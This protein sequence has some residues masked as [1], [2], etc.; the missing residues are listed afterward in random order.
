M[1]RQ[2]DLNFSPGPEYLYG[3]AAYIRAAVIVERAGGQSFGAFS[4]EPI[5]QP[6]GMAHRRWRDDF[7]T[8]IPG[9]ATGYSPRACGGY[10]IH[11]PYSN[12]AGNGGLLTTAGDLLRGNASLD[13]TTGGVGQRGRRPCSHRRNSGTA[14][15]R[16]R[17][18][19]HD[20]R[21]RRRADNFPRLVH[22]GLQNVPGPFPRAPVVL[23][24]ARQRGRFLPGAGGARVAE[25]VAQ[26][27]A[28]VC[29][30]AH[31]RGRGR[32]GRVGGPILRR[33][34]RRSDPAHGAR[35]KAPRR[36]PRERV[37]IGPGL[38]SKPGGGTK[39]LFSTATPRRLRITTRNAAVDYR[40]AATVTPT[41]AHLAFS[42]G[43]YRSAELAVAHR[44]SVEAGR[45]SVGHWPG[46][47]LAAKPAFADG[48]RVG[49][50]WHAPF[51]RDAAGAVTGDELTNGRCRH[52]R[53]SRQ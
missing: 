5:F 18:G 20:H 21:G 11:T 38:F 26:A 1:S 52:V 24:A 23:R 46:L 44:V 35:R 25:G 45:L 7:A 14:A 53:F 41:G 31:H 16:F 43:T 13:G 3:N 17:A 9:R 36:R 37:P 4:R 32:T 42:A 40:A 10:A 30:T 8:V 29:A 50:G 33:A 47:P 28:T 39:F 34:N 2:R 48:F 12:L 19:P 49:R 27:A 22:V 51:T 6:R 15:A